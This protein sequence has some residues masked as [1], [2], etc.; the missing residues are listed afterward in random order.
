MLEIVAVNREKRFALTD[1]GD[2]CPITSFYDRFGDDTDDPFEAISAV[3]EL[4]ADH[5]FAID[6]TKFEPVSVN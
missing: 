1:R 3:A 2:V 6:L 4:D 5:W